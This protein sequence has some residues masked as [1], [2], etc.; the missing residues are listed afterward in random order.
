[1]RIKLSQV[2]ISLLS[3]Y[4]LGINLLFLQHSLDHR[5]NHVALSYNDTNVTL[6]NTQI[7][8]VEVSCELCDFFQNQVYFYF[9]DQKLTLFPPSIWTRVQKRFDLFTLSE[10]TIKLRGPPRGA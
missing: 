2:F 9:A 1:M 3:L 8:S 6:T 7:T 5:D 4:L 10:F